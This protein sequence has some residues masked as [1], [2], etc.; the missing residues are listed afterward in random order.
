VELLGP[1]KGGWGTTASR[2]SKPSGMKTWAKVSV[3][4]RGKGLGAWFR[5]KQ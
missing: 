3:S 2:V 1:E 4:D 5:G